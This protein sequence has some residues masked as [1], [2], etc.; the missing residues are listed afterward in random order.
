MRT[1]LALLAVV[2]FLAFLAVGCDSSSDAEPV[3]CDAPIGAIV[4]RTELSGNCGPVRPRVLQQDDE[5]PAGCTSDVDRAECFVSGFLSCTEDGFTVT[6]EWWLDGKTG[7]WLGEDHLQ[8]PSCRSTYR[9]QL[10]PR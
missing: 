8:T 2:A 10:D 9:L 3:D 4:V 1:L 7:R 5:V 6:R